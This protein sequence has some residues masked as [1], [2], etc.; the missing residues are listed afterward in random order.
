[1]T[2]RRKHGI[3]S[4]LVA[5]I[6][7]KS[8]EEVDEI[9]FEATL[10]ASKN[11]LALKKRNSAAAKGKGAKYDQLKNK[12]KITYEK[13][14]LDLGKNP[15]WKDFSKELETLYK[16]EISPVKSKKS[17]VGESAEFDWVGDTVNG[18]WRKLNKDEKLY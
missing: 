14:K 5:N 17:K 2:D 16:G 6:K 7:G 10:E 4:L 3:G 11:I 1:M 15:S 13:L 12:A 9:A 8:R 18:W